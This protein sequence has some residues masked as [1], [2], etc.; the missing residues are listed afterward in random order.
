[1]GGTYCSIEKYD[2][3][4]MKYVTSLDEVLSVIIDQ[5]KIK[6][7]YSVGATFILF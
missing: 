7:I 2:S 5:N 4:K 1:M 6:P 3:V